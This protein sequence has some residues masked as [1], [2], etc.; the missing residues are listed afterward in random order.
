MNS[1]YMQYSVLIILER[2]TNQVL[3]IIFLWIYGSTFMMAH[4]ISVVIV[5]IEPDI[6]FSFQNSSADVNP[7]IF[8]ICMLGFYNQPIT[9]FV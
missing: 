1:W 2:L 6:C 7:V 8:S 3:C 9:V 5:L 4:V